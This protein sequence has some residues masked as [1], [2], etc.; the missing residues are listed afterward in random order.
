ML[1][2]LFLCRPNIFTLRG[3]DTVQL[4][5]TANELRKAGVE[6]TIYQGEE[7]LNYRNFDLLHFFNII[8]CEDLLE[9]AI[10]SEVPYLLSTIYVDYSEYDRHHRK[11]LIGLLSR[12]LTYNQIEYL[13]TTGKFIFRGERISHHSYFIMGHK[14]AVK[15][16]LQKAACLLPNSEHEYERLLVG[17]GIEKKYFVVPNGIDPQ[18]FSEK[19][20]QGERDIVLCVARIEG[21]KNQ[22]NLIRAMNGTGIKTIIIGASS[23]NQKSYVAQCRREA[24]ANIE[25]VPEVSQVELL[26]YYARA[27]V[28]VLPSWFETTGLSSLEAAAMGCNIVVGQRGDVRDYFKNYVHYCEPGNIRSIREAILQAWNEPVNAQLK[29]LVLNNYTWQKA[30]EATITAYHAVLTQNV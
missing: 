12:F 28:H 10:K 15:Y 4:E 26:G 6:V 14:G 13:K 20:Y 25:F 29:N 5:N 16:I 19:E 7:P 17:Y 22:L 9:H 11:D 18:L 1:K 24:D 8:D 2:I 3:G 21:R 27:K 30:A 23:A